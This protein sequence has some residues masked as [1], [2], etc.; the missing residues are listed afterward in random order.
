MTDFICIYMCVYIYTHTN[1]HICTW[2]TD[3]YIH[4][5]RYVSIYIFFFFLCDLVSG[6]YLSVSCEIK[7][8]ISLCDTRFNL[9][10]N[11]VKIT[12]LL[13]KL[14]NSQYCHW[15]QNINTEKT[16][17]KISPNFEAISTLLIENQGAP[18]NSVAVPWLGLCVSAAGN[19][20]LIAGP[21]TKIPQ[22]E[23]QGKK[24]IIKEPQ[25]TN[26]T[27]TKWIH[28]FPFQMALPAML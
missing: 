1:I 25:T 28:V 17:Q 13:F 24:K 22:T 14:L 15:L 7:I 16:I 12:L 8:L 4:I 19:P 6:K 27:Y 2:I 21:E 5:C 26:S 11:L 3:T 10:I 18:G 23:W 20:G 9:Y